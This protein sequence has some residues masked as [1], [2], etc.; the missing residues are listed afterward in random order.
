ML[1]RKAAA[2]AEKDRLY[3]EDQSDAAAHADS[4]PATKEK[5]Y[6]PPADFEEPGP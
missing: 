6:L 3:D 4:T 2:A 5:K 1:K